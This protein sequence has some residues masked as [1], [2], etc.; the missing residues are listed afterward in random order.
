MIDLLSAIVL[1]IFSA[2]VQS[3]LLSQVRILNGMSDLILLFLVSWLYFDRTRHKWILAIIAGVFSGLISAI[4]Y[5]VFIIIYLIITFVINMIHQRIWQAPLV[6]LFLSTI[7]AAGIT[8]SIQYIYLFVVGV[9]I[10][11]SDSLN[12]VILP[13]IVFN[14]IL[15][16]PV[17]AITGEIVKLLYR[18]EV[19][20]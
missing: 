6:V 11:V 4:P 8:Y 18:E 1:M 12:L 10:S 17:Y 13:S 15:I 5:W 16:L 19:E 20:I 2:I 3:S 14:V 7:I 9:P